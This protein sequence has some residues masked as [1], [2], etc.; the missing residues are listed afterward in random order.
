MAKDVSRGGRMLE[1][2][3]ATAARRKESVSQQRMA[4]L[5]TEAL[6]RKVHQP[7]WSSYEAGSEAPLDVIDGAARLSGLTR[8]YLGWGNDS[9][10]G[11]TGHIA[12]KNPL[13]I[14]EAKAVIA[15]RSPAEPYLG[16]KIGDDNA[17]SAEVARRKGKHRRR[18][19]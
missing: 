17:A 6:G 2:R 5:L 16:E 4:D 10:V 15:S 3:L 19:A 18:R 13:T 11:E 7:Q 14:E 8:D 1:A 12:G 9:P